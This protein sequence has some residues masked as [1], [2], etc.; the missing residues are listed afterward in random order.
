LPRA[1]PALRIWYTPPCTNAPGLVAGW[2]EREQIETND[3]MLRNLL[4]PLEHAIRLPGRD[5]PQKRDVINAD[6]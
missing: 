5:S 6:R 2:Q 1:C 3:R 4:D